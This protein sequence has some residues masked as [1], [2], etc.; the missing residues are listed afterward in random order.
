MLGTCR[1]NALEYGLALLAETSSAVMVGLFQDKLLLNALQVSVIL[2]FDNN[3]FLFILA[4]VH[5]H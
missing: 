5:V 1:V 4:A 3:G 2:A